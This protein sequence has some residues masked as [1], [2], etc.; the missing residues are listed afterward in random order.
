MSFRPRVCGGLSKRAVVVLDQLRSSPAG[1]FRHEGKSGAGPFRGR[2]S[3]DRV[4]QFSTE[5][6]KYGNLLSFLKQSA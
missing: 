1:S 4:M 2:G 3:S 5:L 6:T